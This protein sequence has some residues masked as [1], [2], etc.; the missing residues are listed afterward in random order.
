MISWR[1]KQGADR[2]IRA[3][4]PW[5]FSNELQQSPK[6]HN[7]GD[8]ILLRD[9]RGDFL[10]TGYGNPHSLIA[11]RALNLDESLSKASL[12]EIVQNKIVQSWYRRQ[13]MGYRFSFRWVYGENDQLPGLVIDRYTLSEHN[14]VQVIVLQVLTAGMERVLGTNLEQISAF[15]EPIIKQTDPQKKFK[16]IFVLRNDVSVRKLEGLSVNETSYLDLDNAG[17]TESN[18]RDVQIQVRESLGQDSLSMSCDLIDGQKTGFFLDQCHNI[19]LLCRILSQ[20]KISNNKIKILDMCSYV[21]HWSTQITHSLKSKNIEVTATLADISKTALTFAKQNVLR[22]GGKYE[23]LECDILEGLAHLPDRS[24]D[25]VIADPPAFIKSKKDIPT[26]KHAY[27]KLN[28]QA[29]RLVKKNGF[30]L[31][32]SCSAHFSEEDMKETLKKSMRRNNLNSSC[33]VR[34]GHG[35]DH[36]N[37]LSFSEGFYLKMFLHQV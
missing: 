22:A 18:L 20:S 35:P 14:N 31:S 33:I 27:L 12:A 13:D 5:I 28:T 2:R 16:N 36:P 7:P 32:S 25:I 1:L 24:F 11:F 15:F 37:D 26:G 9:H 10:A 30:V 3:G 17:L 6:G 19:E 23:I 4:H 21:G 8:P 34:G 29:F